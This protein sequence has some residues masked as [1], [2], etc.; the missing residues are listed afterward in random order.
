MQKVRWGIVGPGKIAHQ[1]ANDIRFT[2]NSEIVAVASNSAE[3][4]Q[5]FA[6]KYSIPT[7]YSDYQSLYEAEDVD[8]VYVATTHNFHFENSRDAI[9]KGKGVLCEKPITDNL[10]SSLKL[11]EIASVNK[12]YLMEALWTYFLPAIQKAKEWIQEGKIGKVINLKSDFGFQKEF[13]PKSR[14]YN[15]EL[16]GGVLLDMGIYPVAMSWYFL[17]QKPEKYNVVMTKAPTGVD[18]DI[19]L[20]LMYPDITANLHS[21]FRAKLSNYTYIIGEEGYIVLPEFWRASECYLYQGEQVIDQF[22]DHRKGLG[23][24]FEIEAAAKDWKNGKIV[25]SIM[26]PA[27][28]IALQELMSEIAAHY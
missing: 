13:D 20:Q 14:L 5:E 9:L 2:S 27:N 28:S 6:G 12:V 17:G 3:R 11:F 16:S 19:N 7:A 8:M 25:S 23:F 22:N 4:A 10:A 21:S 26:S 1:F 15:P 18:Y 24:E